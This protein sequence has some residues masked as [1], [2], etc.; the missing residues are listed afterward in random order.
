MNRFLPIFVALVVAVSANGT[1]LAQMAVVDGGTHSLLA[2]SNADEL[3]HWADQLARMREQ[4]DTMRKHLDTLNDMK[5]AVGNPA[6]AVG[7]IDSHFI[8]SELGQSGLGATFGEL[9]RVGG[10]VSGL[11]GEV[12]GLYA[13]INVTNPLERLNVSG[14]DVFGKFRAVESAFSRYADVLEDTRRREK[15]IELKLKDAV[16]RLDTAAT[17]AEAQKIQGELAALESARARL[18]KEADDA[19]TQ[20]DALNTL[21]END[22]RMRRLQTSARLKAEQKAMNAEARTFFSQPR[23]TDPN[24]PRQLVLP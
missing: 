15:D 21:N 1:A 24:N 4:V 6:Q 11:T 9:A 13:P 19:A 5:S 3:V 22:E 23:R 17:D 18:A 20:V 2:K 14:P 10:S 7:L 8:G 16:A 12:K